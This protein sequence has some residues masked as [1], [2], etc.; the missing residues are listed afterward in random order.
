VYMINYA[1]GPL[2]GT[3][4]SKEV[5]ST[6]GNSSQRQWFIDAAKSVSPPL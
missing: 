2:D 5:A 3:D 6:L 1:P 4:M